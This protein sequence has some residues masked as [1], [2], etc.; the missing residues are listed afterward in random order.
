MKTYG[1]VDQ[2]HAPAAL[3]RAKYSGTH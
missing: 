3:I 1:G 2:R